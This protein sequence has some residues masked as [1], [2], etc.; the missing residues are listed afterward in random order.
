MVKRFNFGFIVR[1]VGSKEKEKEV[2]RIM[3]LGSVE[4][5]TWIVSS[6]RVLGSV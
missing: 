3:T 2:R 5:G 6:G 1:L 4:F